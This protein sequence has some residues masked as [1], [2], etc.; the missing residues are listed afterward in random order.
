MYS[1]AFHY[2]ASHHV[3]SFDYSRLASPSSVRLLG[4]AC[5]LVLSPRWSVGRRV[6]ED[7][8]VVVRR[9]RSAEPDCSCLSGRNDV[10]RPVCPPPPGT[11]AQWIGRRDPR[12]LAFALLADQLSPSL[13][14]RGV[15]P[16]RQY[17]G[18]VRS[19]GFFPRLTSGNRSST[20]PFAIA[21]AV[22]RRRIVTPCCRTPRRR[23]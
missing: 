22:H 20:S 5:G 6:A 11:S 9:R 19:L 7:A 18:Y 4:P 10:A 23:P 13:H 2:H 1:A 3:S 17:G 21:V 12:P 16:R 15:D 14:T 8:V